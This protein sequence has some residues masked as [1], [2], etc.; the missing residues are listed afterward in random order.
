MPITAPNPGDPW[1]TT[2]GQIITALNNFENTWAEYN[3]ATNQVYSSATQD[4]VAFGTANTTSSLVTRSADGVGHRFTLG[5]AGLWGFSTI[6]RWGASTTDERYILLT[7]TNPLGA[8]ATMIGS[9]T[10]PIT[11]TINVVRYMAL[12]DF[13]RVECWEA[14]GATRSLQSDNTAAW[15]RINLAWLHA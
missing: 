3:A 8:S 2:G 1:A 6:I 13:V 4:V 12:N 5:R 10:G 9:F 14:S 15:G 11:L 7:G